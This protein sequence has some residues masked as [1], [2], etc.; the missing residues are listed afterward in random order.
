[1]NHTSSTARKENIILLESLLFRQVSDLE[2]RG[3]TFIPGE[4]GCSL[5]NVSTA[6]SPQNKRNLLVFCQGFC[7]HSAVNRLHF[8]A[9]ALHRTGMAKHATGIP[10]KAS[11]AQCLPSRAWSP[12]QLPLPPAYPQELIQRAGKQTLE[13]AAEAYPTFG[14]HIVPQ[15]RF[16]P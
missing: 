15:S 12:A 4:E 11:R 3:C 13:T 16:V 6:T 8:K 9:Q 14:S 7:V 5:L 10:T 1:M 2:K